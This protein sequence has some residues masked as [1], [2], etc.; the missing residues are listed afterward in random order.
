M[1]LVL[2]ISA[3]QKQEFDEAIPPQQKVSEGDQPW[4]KYPLD[5]IPGEIDPFLKSAS[6]PATA[7]VCVPDKNVYQAAPTSSVTFNSVVYY[8]GSLVSAVSSISGSTITFTMKRK[9]GLTFPAGSVFRIKL[10]NAGGS[11]IVTKTLASASATCVLSLTE[12]KTWNVNGT[13]TTNTSNWSLYVATWYNPTSRLNFYSS[14]IRLVAVPSGWGV[15]L[16]SLNNV[17]V[18]SN[19]WGGFSATDYLRDA[20][21]NNSQKYQC[22]HYIQ[23]YYFAIYGKNIGNSDAGDY[24]FNYTSH[25]L[26]AKILNGKGIPKQGDI[27][28]FSS[29]KGSHHVGIVLGFLAPTGKIRV[30]QENVGQTLVNGNYCSAYKDFSFTSTST[31]YN[32]SASALGSTWTTLGWVR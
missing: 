12:S 17:S 20:S 22:V 6:Y 31:G 32:I 5:T 29:S 15:N 18:Y 24:W 8:G 14:S 28:C 7:Y 13:G 19:G 16:G 4:F 2:V 30:F 10:S 21:C 9:D 11:T 1:T 23:K 3:C 25:K 27:I 26:T